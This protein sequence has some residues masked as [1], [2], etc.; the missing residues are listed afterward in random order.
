VYAV[1]DPEYKE[2]ILDLKQRLQRLREE[3]GDSDKD[4]PW[5]QDLLR[6]Q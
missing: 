1:C 4:Q 6:N 3:L 2:I 5:I